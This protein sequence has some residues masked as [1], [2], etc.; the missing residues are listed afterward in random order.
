MSRVCIL[1]GPTGTE[2]T[3]R[4]VHL[5]APLWSAAALDSAP[6][7]LVGIH[8][9]Y[10]AAG[11]D[12]HT[13]ATF[14]TRRR[15][16]GAD[17]E[18]LTRAAVE[19]LR[20]TLSPGM[21][22]AGSVAPLEDCYRPELSPPESQHEHAELARLLV[23]LGCDLLLCETFPHV[24]EGLQA[25]RAAAGRGVPVWTAFTAGYQADL[26]TP[27][28][29]AEGARAAVDAGA[30]AVLVNCVPAEH[31]LAFVEALVA[32]VGDQVPV[33]AY[34][35]AGPVDGGTGWGAGVAGARRYVALAERWVDAGATL[36]GGCCGTE[37][38]TIAALR[39][40]WPVLHTS[41][42]SGRTGEKGA[43]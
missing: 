10:V 15:A 3:R 32:A 5:P 22:L 12:V 19:M 38:A 1:D 43:P 27:A 8:A 33:G 13:A 28:A 21:R 35:N 9:D 40:R 39:D 11:A 4:G 7:V 20:G 37:P 2:L 16:A 34:A 23:S 26:L 36:I 17:W 41:T 24:G 6:G 29:V 14:R 18:R 42:H 31:T 25:T 30:D